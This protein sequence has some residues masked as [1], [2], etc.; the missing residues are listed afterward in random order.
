MY[1]IWECTVD[2]THDVYNFEHMLLRRSSKTSRL[3][4]KYNYTKERAGA[5]MWKTK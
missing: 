3:S 2:K 1:R 4:V 5:G